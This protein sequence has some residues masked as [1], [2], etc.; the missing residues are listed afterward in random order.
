MRRI[1]TITHRTWDASFLPDTINLTLGNTQRKWEKNKRLQWHVR[2]KKKFSQAFLFSTSVSRTI[3]SA[4][5]QLRCRPLHNSITSSI[6]RDKHF[7]TRMN[8]SLSSEY[9]LSPLFSSAEWKENFKA[10][11]YESSEGLTYVFCIQLMYLNLF[12]ITDHA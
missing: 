1:F 4:P 3:C 9:I 7:V 11:S 2:N 12:I 10:H 6:D 8:K 5:W